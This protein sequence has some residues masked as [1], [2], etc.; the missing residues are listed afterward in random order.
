[1]SE[2]S[3]LIGA[4]ADE[5][6]QIDAELRGLDD[7]AAHQ[8]EQTRGSAAPDLIE[9]LVLAVRRAYTAR[10][11]EVRSRRKIVQEKRGDLLS[12]RRDLLERAGTYRDYLATNADRE[13]RLQQAQLHIQTAI[14]LLD[15]TDD[16]DTIDRLGRAPLR[17]LDRMNQTRANLR[18]IERRL[19]ELGNE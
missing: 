10:D 9:A 19:E 15:R 12:E 2:R 7:E 1:M 3:G 8:V 11:M 14:A 4:A 6:A 17:L 5:L 16:W 18:G 13:V